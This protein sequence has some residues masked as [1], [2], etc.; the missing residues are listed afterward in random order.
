M[1]FCSRDRKGSWAVFRTLVTGPRSHEL[2][3][4]GE[5]GGYASCDRSCGFLWGAAE[6][7]NSHDDDVCQLLK[8]K[9]GFGGTR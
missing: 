2:P 3:S 8:W 7:A 9:R 4:A 1:M 5:H 6:A